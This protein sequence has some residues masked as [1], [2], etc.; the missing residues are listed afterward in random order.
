MATVTMMKCQSCDSEDVLADAYAKWNIDTQEWELHN[1]FDNGSYCE[2]CEGEAR[3]IEE[4]VQR[5]FGV[6]YKVNDIFRT[7]KTM[8]EA[9]E[10]WKLNSDGVPD[11]TVKYFISKTQRVLYDK[12]EGEDTSRPTHMG[13]CI[14]DSWFVAVPKS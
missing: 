8:C 2:N 14:F 9:V 4:E 6:C 1:T 10:Y 12:Q 7:S 3:I 5:E 13:Y 11:K